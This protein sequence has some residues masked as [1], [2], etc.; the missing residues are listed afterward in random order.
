MFKTFWLV[1]V[2]FFVAAPARAND[3][4]ISAV[5]LLAQDTSNA[6]LTNH[7]RDI[8]FTVAWSNSWCMA[9]AAC[10]GAV[11][12]AGG[13]WD[14]VWVFAKYAVYTNGAWGVWNHCTL[15]TTGHTEPAGSQIVTPSDGKGVFIYRDGAGSGTNT[16]TN[17][18]IRWRY[19]ADNVSDRDLVKVQVFGV[20]MVY[21]P[22]ESFY[23]GDL[24]TSTASFKQG[25]ADT[26]PWV[27][28]SEDAITT[29]N[30]ASDGYYYVSNSRTGEVASGEVFTI[31][32]DFPKGYNDF[33]IMKY[34]LSQGQWR[35]FLNTLTQ[36]QQ[37]TYT[38]ATLTDEDDANTYVMVAEDQ[39][40]V[41]YR[42][43]IKAGSNPAD[44]MPYTFGCDLDDNDTLDEAADG[45]WIAMNYVS[46]GDLVG[47]ADWAALRPFTELEFEKA[48]RGPLW[49]VAREY[50]WGSTSSDNTAAVD[51]NVGMSSE[52]PSVATDNV[53]V[54][55]GLAGP[56]R[57]GAF[58]R[59]T[60]GLT[61]TLAGASYYGVMELSGNLWDRTVTVGNA[62]GCAFTGLHG[63][64]SLASA[65]AA[66]PLASNATGA[67][68]RGG[69]LS[70]TITQT[71]VSGRFWAGYSSLGRVASIGVRLARTAP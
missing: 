34:E 6:F 41:S 55:A 18:A 24:A 51:G 27:I 32:A 30:T 60:G 36:A 10:A 61:R 63:D 67:G 7:T 54:S 71:R 65:P 29:T 44:G 43:T 70:D 47:V 15:S 14:A 62:T 31:L 37:D 46:W 20:E 35:D 1:L 40:T 49:P 11:T 66:W 23:A 38:A 56:V 19:G 39:A 2:L 16:F 50:A 57:C 58:A 52:L 5:A 3:M 69:G 8:E 21:I 28:S 9:G 25:T 12:N 64:G 33:Y 68:L 59:S 53:L 26:D 42:Q 48:A 22:Q 45:E 4:A 17:A 13:N